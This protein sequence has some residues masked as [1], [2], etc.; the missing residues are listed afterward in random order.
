MWT[1]PS[2]EW[3]RAETLVGDRPI[4]AAICITGTPIA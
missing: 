2:P 1:M 3:A 4:M